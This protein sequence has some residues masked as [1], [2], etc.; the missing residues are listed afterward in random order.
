MKPGFYIDWKDDLFIFD[1]KFTTVWASNNG[2][3]ITFKG[4]TQG[5]WKL[6]E[7]F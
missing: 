2:H 5:S 1:G 7:L 4:C 3:W 6:I